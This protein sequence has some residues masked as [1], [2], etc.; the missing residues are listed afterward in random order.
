MAIARA[1]S[2]VRPPARSLRQRALRAAAPRRAALV[3]SA[4]RRSSWARAAARSSPSRTGRR[5]PRQ[6]VPD[7]LRRD[8][9]GLLRRLAVV[10][11]PRRPPSAAY[12]RARDDVAR[13]SP[14]HARRRSRAGSR[15]SVSRSPSRALDPSVTSSPCFRSAP[16][17]ACSTSRRRTRRPTGTRSRARFMLTA[18]P[19]WAACFGFAFDGLRDA[20]PRGSPACSSC[21]LGACSL[22][23]PSLPLRGRRTCDRRRA[24]RTSGDICASAFAV[25]ARSSSRRSPAGSSTARSTTGRPPRAD[26]ADAFG[27]RS[28][29]RSTPAG[30]HPIARTRA[31]ARSRPGSRTTASWSRSRSRTRRRRSSRRPTS[32]DRAEDRAAPRRSAAASST[33]GSSPRRPSPTQRQTMY[34]CWYE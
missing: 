18:V 9:G 8:L 26:R 15:S 12:A 33:S 22:A 28:S 2:V 14:V 24:R 7:R 20:V 17:P 34:D 31:A 27:A 4:A 19:A 11:G 16:S 25:V 3:A 13:R 23:S 5:S 32:G 6:F 30:E 21:A 10:P 1:R 29:S